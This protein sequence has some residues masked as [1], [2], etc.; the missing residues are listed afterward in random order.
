[1]RR[2]DQIKLSYTLSNLNTLLR[3]SRSYAQDG[4]RVGYVTNRPPVS[5]PPPA[6]IILTPQY[7]L[8][9]INAGVDVRGEVL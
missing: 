4:F 2:T 5:F 3:F 7:L 6:I 1:M 9:V 8:L